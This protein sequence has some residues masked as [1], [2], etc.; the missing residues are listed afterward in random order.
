MNKKAFTLIELLAVIV[1]LSVLALLTS[2]SMTKILKDSRESISTTQMKLIESAAKTWGAANINKLPE[3]GNCA[4]ITLKD[5][6]NAGL[7]SSSIIDSTTNEELP[8][9]LKVKISA[10]ANSNGN[11]I[12]TYEINPESIN[13]CMKAI[14]SN[15][16]KLLKIII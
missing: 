2:T 3:A 14:Q 7:L 15:E 10:T 1:I 6:K 12:T 11:T 9:S 13:G 5:L 8:N 16:E 4:Y